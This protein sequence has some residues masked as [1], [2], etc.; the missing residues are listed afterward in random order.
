MPVFDNDD[1]A[2]ARRLLD[3]ETEAKRE[4]NKLMGG[5]NQGHRGGMCRM[6]RRR[7]RLTAC[8]LIVAVVVASVVGTLFSRMPQGNES[9]P[10]KPI[11]AAGVPQSISCSANGVS[12][13]AKWLK[14]SLKQRS[15]IVSR[16]CILCVVCVRL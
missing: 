5:E 1:E 6:L 14:P 8:S 10:V 9:Q 15:Q 7:K 13:R 11:P 3:D 16:F 12:L 2:L 4:E